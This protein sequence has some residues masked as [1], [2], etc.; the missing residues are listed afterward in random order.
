[1][2]HEVLLGSGPGKVAQSFATRSPLA[3][4]F[5]HP[6]TG[7]LSIR[8]LRDQAFA[9][10]SKEMQ[11]SSSQVCAVIVSASFALSRRS[12]ANIPVGHVATTVGACTIF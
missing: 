12:N 3:Q 9:M 8:G 7:P 6:K 11:L 1:M 4:Y 5:G 2:L 10:A